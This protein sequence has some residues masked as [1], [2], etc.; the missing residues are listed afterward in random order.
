MKESAAA[1]G[2]YVMGGD[3]G[4]GVEMQPTCVYK[5]HQILCNTVLVIAV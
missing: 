3:D 1:T 5:Y 2:C 4:D